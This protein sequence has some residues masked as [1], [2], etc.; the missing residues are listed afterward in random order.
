[1]YTYSSVA[2]TAQIPPTLTM[3]HSL[4]I[5]VI[6]RIPHRYDQKSVSQMILYSIKLITN[7]N[8]YCRII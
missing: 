2:P 7:N 4:A 8:N 5:N 3:D 6:K 1:M